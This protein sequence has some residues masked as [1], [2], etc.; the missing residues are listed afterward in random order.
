LH[1][2]HIGYRTGDEDPVTE[3]VAE[4]RE[5][6]RLAGTHA[7]TPGALLP[8]LH[9]IQERFGHIPAPAIAVVADVL[10]LSRA[11]VHGVVSF[12]HDFRARPPGRHVVK[13]CRAEACQAVGARALERHAAAALGVGFG[14]TTADGAITLEPVY[15]LGNC[16]AGPSMMIDGEPV[17]RVDAVAFDAAVAALRTP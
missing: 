10:N 16:A 13:L 14:E 2:H 12:Y 5:L 7:G 9:A 4:E 6:R 17:G 15:C 1:A 3:V 8:V 11:D